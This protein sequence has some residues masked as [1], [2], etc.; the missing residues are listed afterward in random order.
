[1][2]PTSIPRKL[3]K[4]S[5]PSGKFLLHELHGYRHIHSKVTTRILPRQVVAIFYS[6][7]SVGQVFLN[8]MV[9]DDGHFFCRLIDQESQ[10]LF[11][12]IP[13]FCFCCRFKEVSPSWF[14]QF[15]FIE[16]WSFPTSKATTGFSSAMY[17]TQGLMVCSF[18]NL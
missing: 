7:N 9:S 6:S 11:G 3:Q 14:Y 16:S 5:L 4:S 15:D 18:R 8:L 10:S 12:T 17:A 2:C 1:M 13:G